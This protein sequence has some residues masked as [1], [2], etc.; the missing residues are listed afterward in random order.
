MSPAIVIEAAVNVHLVVVGSEF[1]DRH[2]Q[3][4]DYLRSHPEVA[5]ERASGAG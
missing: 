2:L 4:R 5:A 1:W 3:F